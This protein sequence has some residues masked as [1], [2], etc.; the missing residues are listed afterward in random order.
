MHIFFCKDYY[1]V[2]WSEGQNSKKPAIYGPF[3]ASF[4]KNNVVVSPW[5]EGR[6]QGAWCEQNYTHQRLIT[7]NFMKQTIGQTLVE[8]K[9]TQRLIRDKDDRC[10]VHISMEMKG[11]PYADCFVVEV[12]HVASRIG[13]QDLI[14]QVGMYVRFVKGCLFEGKIRNNTGTETSNAQGELLKRICEGC[15]EYAVEVVT[16]EED[17]SDGLT[18]ESIASPS[19]GEV[20][21]TNRST[22]VI[23]ANS[24]V[25]TILLLLATLFR[26]YVLPYLPY[27]YKYIQPNTVDEALKDVRQRITV[28]R[29]LSMKSFKE[30][31]QQEVK[32]EIL[33]IE[34]SLTRIEQMNVSAE[35]DD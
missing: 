1:E 10:I 27:E 14:V 4:G 33:A 31:E 28:L 23:E 24:A 26:K 11:F 20:A 17:Q 13:K 8:V 22:K 34:K 6:F 18:D 3:L 19:N 2:A 29:E 30:E 35:L 21:P 12:R 5:E 16:E 7:F 15:K 9:H 25:Q 32:N